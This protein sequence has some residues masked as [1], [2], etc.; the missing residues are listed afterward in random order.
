MR[1]LLVKLLFKNAIVYLERAIEDIESVQE[2]KFTWKEGEDPFL[3]WFELRH[4]ILE[5]KRS[6]HTLENIKRRLGKKND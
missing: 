5:L 1:K 3:E 2:E 6:I 4:V